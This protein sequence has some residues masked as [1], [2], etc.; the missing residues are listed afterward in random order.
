MANHSKN[1]DIDTAKMPQLKRAKA[2]KDRLRLVVINA[3]GVKHLDLPESGQV[4]IG[5]GKDNDIQLDD[6]AVSRNH[7][8]IE[9]AETLRIVDLESVNGSRVRDQILKPGNSM[10]FA[11][12]DSIDIGQT[13]LVVQR[14]T[15]TARPRRL[16]SHAYF[17]LRLEEECQRA[18]LEDGK[19]AIMR[20]HVEKGAS[21][22]SLNEALAMTFP[23]GHLIAS[24]GPDEF[25]VMLL[26]STKNDAEEYTR[27]LSATFGQK[28]TKMCV[29]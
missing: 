18:S 12:G 27:R 24:Y 25:E 7:I 9:I 1:T 22:A 8:R 11:I 29:F 14:I 4:T 28:N 10:D 23:R 2:S 15:P 16:C 26:S 21:A 3:Q 5:R 17:E 13:M 6:T 19:F 20:L